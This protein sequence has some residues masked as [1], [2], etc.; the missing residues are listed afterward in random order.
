MSNYDGISLNIIDSADFHRVENQHCLWS[1]DQHT[2]VGVEPGNGQLCRRYIK[3]K[4][5]LE[6]HNL[7]SLHI[8]LVALMKGVFGAF[9]LSV[10]N[11]NPLTWLI[12]Q[13]GK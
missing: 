2:T 3:F 9:I 7:L 4:D 5:F 11:E 6:A 8:T 13:V 10:L 1:L 12:A